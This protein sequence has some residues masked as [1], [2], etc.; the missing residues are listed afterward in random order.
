MGDVRW[1]SDLCR[2]QLELIFPQLNVSRLQHAPNP[3]TVYLGTPWSERTAHLDN[4][5]AQTPGEADLD[6][7]PEVEEGGR[8]FLILLGHRLLHR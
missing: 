6:T 1:R 3:D 2:Y 7:V 4:A 8:S 5:P